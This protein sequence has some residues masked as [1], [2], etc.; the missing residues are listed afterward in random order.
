[1]PATFAQL[2]A[3]EA[4]IPAMVDHLFSAEPEPLPGFMQLTR[5]D[6]EAIYRLCL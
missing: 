4:D 2:G 3:N 6:V 5:N 1:M